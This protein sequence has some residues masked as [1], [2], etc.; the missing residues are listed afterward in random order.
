MS[1]PIKVTVDART[2]MLSL[3]R[4]RKAADIETKPFLRNE[5]RLSQEALATIFAVK[6]EKAEKR[7]KRERFIA[8]RFSK[9]GKAQI[10][11]QRVRRVIGGQRAG[12][13]APTVRTT[14]AIASV[15]HAITRMG[16][17]AAG[18][19]TPRNPYNAAAMGKSHVMQ[20]VGRS[21]GTVKEV[22]GFGRAHITVTNKTPYIG[23]MR[24]ADFLLRKVRK[25]RYS[26]T[27]SRLKLITKGIAK[28]KI[29]T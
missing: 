8:Y 24:G 3:E 7:I 5:M 23:F 2:M 20:N 16:L 11:W 29:K 1:N 22:F 25:A 18:W 19:I 12:S 15:R 9:T 14:M 10:P 4:L 17:V 13:D 26:A 28:Y 6:K 21:I 27:K